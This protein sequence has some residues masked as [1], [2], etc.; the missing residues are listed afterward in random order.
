MYGAGTSV[1]LNQ[2]FLSTDFAQ[3]PSSGNRSM[4]G[5]QMDEGKE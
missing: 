3:N 2:A 1:R 4:L 5:G